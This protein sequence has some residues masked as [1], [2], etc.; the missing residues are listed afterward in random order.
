MKKI[1]GKQF[2]AIACTAA[3]ALFALGG[4]AQDSSSEQAEHEPLT[5]CNINGLVT[6]SFLETFRETHPEVTFD[7]SAYR[8]ANGSGYA[9][10]TLEQ[11]DIPDIYISTQPFSPEAQREYLIDLANYDFIGNYATTMLNSVDNEG[12]IYLLPSC[13]QMTGISYNKTI[14]EENGW[15]V[16]TSLEELLAL[17][18]KIEAAGYDVMRCMF[19]LDGYPFNYFFNILN[20][21]Y[22]FTAAGSEWKEAFPKG[23]AT[24]AD[25]EALLAGVKYFERWIDAG[26]I[27]DSSDATRGPQDAFMNGECVFFLSLGL[28]KY[29]NTTED[30]RTYEFDVIPWL[31]ADGSTNALTTTTSRYFGLSKELLDPGNEQKLADALALMEFVSTLEGQEALAANAADPHLYTAPLAGAGLP[32]DNPFY[33]HSQLIEEGHT[34][35]LVYEG[36]EDLIVPIAQD[37]RKLVSGEVTAEQLLEEFDRTYAEVASGEDGSI[38]TLEEDL[39]WDDTVRLCAIATGRAVDADAALVSLGGYNEAR[40]VNDRGVAWYVYAGKLTTEEINMF[41]PKYWSINVFQMTGAEI[42]ALAEGGFDLYGSGN[43]FPYTLVVKGDAELADDKVYRLAVGT[44]ELTEDMQARTSEMVSII[45]QQA[46]IDYLSAL[47]TFSAK[48]I[49]WE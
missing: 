21:D 2:A 7:A 30:G 17:M 33:E 41:R 27:T 38:A 18:P 48:D 14:M 4:C 31:S 46:I 1:L 9:M 43:P 16:P 13:Y 49:V 22:F 36:W 32:E 6:D 39:G 47:G 25:N 12:G 8:G 40:E 26:L 11:G 20:T 29:E 28:T 23:E 24:A 35:Q 44:E 37:I 34:V 45:S 15:E 42:K 3:L 5:I 19:D 10:A